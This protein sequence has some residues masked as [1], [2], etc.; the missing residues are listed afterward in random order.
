ML[1]FVEISPADAALHGLEE[2]S[3][4]KLVSDY[5]SAILSVRLDEGQHPGM[6]FAP[7]HWTAETSSDGR[8]G[9]AVQPM[10]DPFSGQPEM[11]ATPVTLEPVPAETAGFIVSRDPIPEPKGW[12][13]SRVMI[14]G[15]HGMLVM[16]PGRIIPITDLAS[17]FSILFSGAA[18][19]EF[20]DARAGVY[21][22]AKL[23]GGRLE[24]AVFLGPAGQS[25]I[26]DAVKPLIAKGQLGD[27]E[28]L[29]VLSGHS[30]D[31]MASVG[32]TICACFGVGL[33]VIT[34]AIASGES[35]DVESI[36][37]LLK[38]GTNCGSCIP[39]LKKIVARSI[40][41][42]ASHGAVA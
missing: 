13:W 39:E 36:G 28:R 9:A 8:V 25:P 4:V 24:L 35:T 10:A 30:T 12:W 33:T 19:A 14:E 17:D 20:I 2:G 38:A 32:P 26:W 41:V 22:A 16:M 18:S 3:L 40:T 6:L 42:E 5:G 7:I 1:P 31:G 37:R 34:A 15:G 27:T 11:K 29:M 21:R 23:E